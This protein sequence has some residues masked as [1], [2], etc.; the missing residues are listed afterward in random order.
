MPDA[1]H[2]GS[3]TPPIRSLSFFFFFSL[4]G[5]I[6]NILCWQ[7]LIYRLR[8]VFFDDIF[9]GK[10]QREKTKSGV[11]LGGIPRKRVLESFTS[12]EVIEF[13]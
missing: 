9:S 3:I 6:K 5:R 1:T 8:R 11:M 7:I 13:N 10:K 4:D 12:L 2:R